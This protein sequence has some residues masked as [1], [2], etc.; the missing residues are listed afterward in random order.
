MGEKNGTRAAEREREH[1]EGESKAGI[2][3]LYD[4]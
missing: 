3:V 1:L 4:F 2:A